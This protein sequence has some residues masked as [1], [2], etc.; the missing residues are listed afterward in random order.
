MCSEIEKK[1]LEKELA[2]LKA[3]LAKLQLEY[4][5]YSQNPRG[6]GFANSIAARMT[7]I[8]IRIDEI[9]KIFNPNPFLHQYLKE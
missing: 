2:V 6:M 3:D 4:T 5:K 1:Q 9:E 8:R 7:N